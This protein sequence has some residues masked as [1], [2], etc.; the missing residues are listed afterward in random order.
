MSLISSSL[1]AATIG[2]TSGSRPLMDRP[3]IAQR[4]RR[5]ASA[6][7][8]VGMMVGSSVASAQLVPAAFKDSVDGQLDLS[9][10]LLHRQGFLP[11]PII[12]TEPALGYGGG[13][14]LTFFSHSLAEG[15]AK[16]NARLIPPTIFGGAGFY[17]SD[18]SYALAAFIF[19]PARRDQMR[20]LGALGGASLKLDFFGFNPDG[21]LADTPVGYT[22]APLFTIQ[23]FQVRFPGSDVF[24]GAHYEYLRTKS[25]FDQALPPE[26]AE[27]DL[28]ANVG[29]MGASLELDSRDNLLDARRGADVVLKATWY[30]PTFGSDDTFEKYRLHALYYSQP[31]KRWGLALRADARTASDDAPFFEKPYLQMRGLPAMQYANNVAVL[32]ESELRFGIDARWALIGFG[33]LGRVAETFGDLGDAP[34][35]GAGGVGF[36]YLIARALR[37][38]SGIDVAF[39]RGGDFAIYL[40]SGSAWR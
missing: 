32:G 4:H 28:E 33:G 35:I 15:L 25:T 18:K 34:S 13:L 36:R 8:L 9:D 11:M 29:G 37:L 1:P 16:G 20:Y 3:L 23:R 31:T 21:P 5:L 10:W 19:H 38:G 40:Q 39:G 17:T 7:L 12:I 26:I 24:V 14:A 30:G 6:S 22:I 27:R 2:P